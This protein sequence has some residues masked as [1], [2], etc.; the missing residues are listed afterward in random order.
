METKYNYIWYQTKKGIIRVTVGWRTNDHNQITMA[1]SVCSPKDMFCKETGRDRV[2]KK[3]NDANKR[4]ET[5][6]R[7][8]HTKWGKIKMAAH[9]KIKDIS[10]PQTPSYMKGAKTIKRSVLFKNEEDGKVDIY[11]RHSGEHLG[12]AYP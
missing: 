7:P 9:R 11:R 8:A 2:D 4:I 3:L 1:Y 12:T 5:K 10:N 6:M